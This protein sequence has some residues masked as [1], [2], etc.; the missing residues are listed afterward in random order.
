MKNLFLVAA[1]L[2]V[3]YEAAADQYP[4]RPITIVV[5]LGPGSSAD[6][7]TRIVAG[8]LS[9]ELATPV[10]VENRTG[11]EGTL[12][13]LEVSRAV[14]DGYTVLGLTDSM[15]YRV[16]KVPLRYDPQ[17]LTYIAGLGHFQAPWIVSSPATLTNRRGLEGA[18]MAHGNFVGRMCA[19]RYRARVGLPVTLIPYPSEPQAL[20]DVA[21]GRV[22]LMCSIPTASRA[23]V[24]KGLLRVHGNDEELIPHLGLAGPP[25]LSKAVVSALSRV[26]GRVLTNPA[27]IEALGTTSFTTAFPTTPEHYRESSIKRS[28]FLNTLR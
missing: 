3:P 5:G 28:A 6:I 18:T 14:P 17:S 25:G 24:E 20:A 13:A 26:V 11:A 12:A 7:V 2:L 23:L 1:L 27:T 19:Y 15:L 21:A 16:G 9:R 8:A 22:S 4:K 10:V